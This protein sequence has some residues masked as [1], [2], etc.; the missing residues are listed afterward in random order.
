MGPAIAN[1]IT[2]TIYN[3]IRY[4]FLI[5][6]FK[7]QP[8]TLKTIYTIIMGVGAFYGCYFLF[9]QLHGLLGMVS[10]SIVFLLLFI[11]GAF[12]LK[13]SPDLLPVWQVVQKRLGIKKGE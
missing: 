13:L 5:T 4:W 12:V 10:R 9:N 1:L 6:K 11:S 7:L 2:F 8:F 3:T